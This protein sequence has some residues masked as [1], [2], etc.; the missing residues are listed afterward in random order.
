MEKKYQVFVSSTYED[1][2]EERQEVM[3]ALLELD[4]I[5]VGMELFPA[6][7][8]DKWTLIKKLIEDCDYYILIV[9]GRYGSVNHDGISYTQMEYEYAVKNS[10]P[11]ISFL[12]KD[13]GAI[14]NNKTEQD[15]EAKGKLENFRNLVQ[16]KM[17]SFW[18]NPDD[19]GS[20]VSRSLVKLTKNKP[21]VGWVK[22]DLIPSGDYLKEILDLRKENE[23][24]KSELERVKAEAP[25]G[26]ES[27]QQGEEKFK[28]NF[29]YEIKSPVSSIWETTKKSSSGSI[30]LSWNQIFYTISPLMI[31]EATEYDLKQY[32][33]TYV[34]SLKINQLKEKHPNEEVEDFSIS[35][36][37]FQTIKVQLCALGLITK[38]TKPRSSKDSATYWKLTSYGD[39][40]MVQLRALKREQISANEVVEKVFKT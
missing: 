19:L 20:V 37:D 33:V 16:K 9:G 22:A 40:V 11:V 3:Q 2:Q 31:G 17:C 30:S 21:A 29:S 14:P 12:H 39:K 28:V 38:G 13:P 23:E 35:D 8:D 26:T 15:T 32:L 27:L 18:N 25:K 7:D 6:A 5:P 34:K 10:I 1:L 4:C 36:V 24:L